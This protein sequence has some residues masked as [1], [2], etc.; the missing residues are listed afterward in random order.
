M[1]AKNV[2]Y[3]VEKLSSKYT[4]KKVYAL[5]MLNSFRYGSENGR[6]TTYKKYLQNTVQLWYNTHNILQ[7][8]ITKI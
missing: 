5:N 4:T 6:I 8:Q 2:F 7:V 3:I 1:V